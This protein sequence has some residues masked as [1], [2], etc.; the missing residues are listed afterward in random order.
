[1]SAEPRA[2]LRLIAPDFV[3]MPDAGRCCGS[4]GTYGITHWAESREI[5]RKK[6]DNAARVNAEIM[7]TGCP[8]CMV[9][10]T[11]GAQVTGRAVPT[12]HVAELTAWTM[13]Y[14][15]AEATEA[16]RFRVLKNEAAPAP[17]KHKTP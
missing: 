14:E 11:A 9:Q 3:E 15:P 7:A 6:M 5:L 4:G 12:F 8:S 16:A 10:L 1:V 2:L 17:E 13:G